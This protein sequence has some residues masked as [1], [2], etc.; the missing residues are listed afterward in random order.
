MSAEDRDGYAR[1]A[2]ESQYMHRVHVQ[3]GGKKYEEVHDEAGAIMMLHDVIDISDRSFPQ[4]FYNS[5]ATKNLL[6]VRKLKSNGSRVVC[7]VAI[8]TLEG[9]RRLRHEATIYE[10]SYTTTLHGTVMPMYYGLFRGKVDGHQLTC[11][12]LEYCGDS[13]SKSLHHEDS[14]FREAVLKAY[15]QLH[16]EPVR[17]VKGNYEDYAYQDII[18]RPNGQPCL[19]DFSR[20]RRHTGKCYRSKLEFN[21]S[22]WSVE[23]ELCG[24][25]LAVTDDAA[26]FTSGLLNLIALPKRQ[27][28]VTYREDAKPEDYWPD[29]GAALREEGYTDAQGHEVIREAIERYKEEAVRRRESLDTK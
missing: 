5:D 20:A 18:R 15:E 2:L 27:L 26:F 11:M 8:A 21:T 29:I 1:Q 23:H 22:R 4:Y 10:A 28:T 24:D 9:E 6:Y 17:L 13:L 25:I 12:V 19:I 16:T 7:K 3:P 14:T